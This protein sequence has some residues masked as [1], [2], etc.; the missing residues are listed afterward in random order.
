MSAGDYYA[1]AFFLLA[2]WGAVFAATE[3][4][5]RRQLGHLSGA[6]RATAWGIIATAGILITTL[7]P[8]ALTILSRET[9][10]VAAVLLLIAVAAL[11][12][13]SAARPEARPREFGERHDRASSASPRGRGAG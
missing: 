1:G 13:N 10:L 9:A 2:T 8:A 7:L 11:V 4:L 5:V 12:P 6:T 3:I